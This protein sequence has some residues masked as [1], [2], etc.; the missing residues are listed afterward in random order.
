[1]LSH[2]IPKQGWGIGK[3][4][5]NAISLSKQNMLLS[6]IRMTIMSQNMQ[7]IIG[8]DGKRYSDVLIGYSTLF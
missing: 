1:M 5:N 8:Q 3:D 7:K 2:S 4:W 6:P